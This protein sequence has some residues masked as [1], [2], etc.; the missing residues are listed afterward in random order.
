MLSRIHQ[1]L[2]RLV[3]SVESLRVDV[4]NLR[5]Q[6]GGVFVEDLEQA[7]IQQRSRQTYTVPLPE[8]YAEAFQREAAADRPDSSIGDFPLQDLAD[9]FVTHFAISTVSFEPGQAVKDR[10]PDIPRY[11][12][13]LKCTWILGRM[14][15][16]AELQ[17][18][19]ENSHW[20]SFVRKLEEVN[21][22]TYEPAALP[23][24]SH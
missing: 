9:A 15:S 2:Q 12:N 18:A 8:S 20:P 16:S 14:Q 24:T 23:R 21:T 4:Q 5:R 19:N 13:L 17:N 1:D 3:T 6:L 7:E 10:I 11:T 22:H